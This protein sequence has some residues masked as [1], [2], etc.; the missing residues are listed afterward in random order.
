[1][2]PASAATPASEIG[3]HAIQWSETERIVRRFQM[4]IVKAT[5]RR[6]WR[7]VKSLQH[8]LTHSIHGKAQ[9][10]RRVTENTGSRTAG[11]DG[12]KWRTPRSKSTRNS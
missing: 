11:V 3:W 10:V 4:R 8:L 9:A 1:M 7:K 12:E 2:T 5:K 6:Q